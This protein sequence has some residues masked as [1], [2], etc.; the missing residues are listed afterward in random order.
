MQKIYFLILILP[1]YLFAQNDSISFFSVENNFTN[2]LNYSGRMVSPTQWATTTALKYTTTKGFDYSLSEFYWSKAKNK[3]A[4]T[5][6]GLT[7]NHDWN[8]VFSGSVGYEHWFMRKGNGENINSLN[9]NFNAGLNADFDWINFA[10][11]TMYL[12]GKQKALLENIEIS[13]D[14]FVDEFWKIDSM[15]ISPTV[16]LDWGTTDADLRH[17][18][19]L[20]PE[21][22]NQPAIGRRGNTKSPIKFMIMSYDFYLPIS[23]YIKHFEIEPALHYDL[24]FN[25]SVG[26]TLHDFFYFTLSVN[27]KLPIKH[28]F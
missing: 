1:N 18:P 3:L 28:R 24:P 12:F 5:D 13:H 16:S 15:E 27:Y 2:K 22:V 11:S 21:A 6:L 23:F 10:S 19:A 4:E 25:A 26:E 20:N 8:D 14:F 9:N 17:N 7:Y